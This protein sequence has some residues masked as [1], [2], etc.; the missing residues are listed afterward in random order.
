MHALWKGNLSFG[1]INIPINLYTASVD[2]EL[3]FT[4]L[5]KKD[6]S[7]IRYAKICKEEE[8]EVDYKEIVKAYEISK[9]EYVVL[10]DEDFESVDVKRT[11]TIEIVNFADEDQIDAIF[12][13]KPYLIEPDKGASK[14][15]ALLYEALK[16]SKK[17][18][19]VKY[20]LRNHEH[21]GAIKIYNKALVL[22]QM[23]YLDDIVHIDQFKLPK[24]E[25]LQ[26][27][28]IEMAT[29]LVHQ[30]TG[31]FNPKDF[32]D[33]YSEELKRVIELKASGKTVK[34]KG[35]E[36]VKPT[37]VHDIMALLKE[38]LK[39]EESAKKS[40]RKSQKHHESKRVQ[41]KAKVR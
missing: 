3:K 14:A 36:V 6:N 29:K 16:K 30:L 23:R 11:K 38:S 27:K 19:I 4:L 13:E 34:A 8:K 31:K 9:G 1:L 12:Y 39:N 20:V 22:N 21:I 10:T 5:H 18:A 17:V 40:S 24:E 33:A 15:Y 28:E 41:K 25:H 7:Q 35:E 26:S 32:H 2:R 37:K